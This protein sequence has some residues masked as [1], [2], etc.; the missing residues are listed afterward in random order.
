MRYAVCVT[1]KIVPEHWNI[2]VD[3][4]KRNAKTSK[5]LEKDCLQFDVCTNKMYPYEVFLYEIYASPEAFNAH[6]RSSHFRDFD[7]EASMMIAD[8]Q[9]KTYFLVD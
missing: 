9:V 1:F 4:V 6:L 8:K 7:A 3:L 5:V 2:F